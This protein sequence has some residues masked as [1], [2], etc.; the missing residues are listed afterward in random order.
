MMVLKWEFP[1]ELYLQVQLKRSVL[2]VVT[3]KEFTGLELLEASFVAIP[4]N[5]HGQAM[6][7]AK[8]LKSS[9][10]NKMTEEEIKNEEAGAGEVNDIL[11]DKYEDAMDIYSEYMDKMNYAQEETVKKTQ[12]AYDDM[13]K[14]YDDYLSF[15]DAYLWEIKDG[16]DSD[17]QEFMISIDRK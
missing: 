1:L 8:M 9:K 5:R 2:T 13:K 15:Y 14:I 16:R 12:D 10:V 4:S 11:E 6:A 3:R 7:M 17:L